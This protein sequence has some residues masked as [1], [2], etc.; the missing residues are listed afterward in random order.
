MV[1]VEKKLQG[2]CDHGRF[3]GLRK[4][5]WKVSVVETLLNLRILVQSYGLWGRKWM[6]TW[7]LV[8]FPST[9]F[10]GMNN[11]VFSM[12]S[13][14]FKIQLV[15]L[16]FLT[17][18]FNKFVR[19]PVRN[20]SLILLGFDSIGSYVRYSILTDFSFWLKVFNSYKTAPCGIS[21]GLC[22]T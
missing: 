14:Q 13:Y 22:F 4:N 1:I 8:T 21:M 5:N 6:S 9:F 20:Y 17:I 7:V 19:I 16:R 15:S 2:S 11:Y 18:Y 10:F 3:R 12:S